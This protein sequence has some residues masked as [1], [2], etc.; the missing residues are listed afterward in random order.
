M[1]VVSDHTVIIIGEMQSSSQ[2]SAAVYSLEY[3]SAGTEMIWTQLTDRTGAP[4]AGELNS[5]LRFSTH[6]CI[7]YRSEY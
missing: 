4:P 3:S 1:T 2:Y 7:K 5:T 6:T